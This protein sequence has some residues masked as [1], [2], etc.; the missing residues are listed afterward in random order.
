MKTLKN[1]QKQT[2]KFDRWCKNTKHRFYLQ[3]YY[4]LKNNERRGQFS[5]S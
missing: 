4:K 2:I 5:V 3:I 1:T